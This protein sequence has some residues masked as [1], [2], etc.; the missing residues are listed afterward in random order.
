MEIPAKIPSLSSSSRTGRHGVPRTD[1]EPGV[2]QR[3][4][5][6]LGHET[7][8][9]V[10]QPVDELA[11]ARL[12][13]DDPHS[14]LVLAEVP[15]D[16]HQGAGGAETGHEV[17]HRR[18]V[19][20]DLRAG[21]LVMGERVGGVS[22]LVEHHPVGMLLG[23]LLGDPDRLVGTPLGGRGDDL[24]APHAQQLAPLLGQVFSGITHTSR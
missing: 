18:Q 3:G 7:L 19:L 15:P 16:A 17:R 4:V 12:G 24:R 14:G 1:R 21:A 13:R 22:V 10:A 6:Q 11:V 5:V 23:H 2:D 20:E 9:E 8:V